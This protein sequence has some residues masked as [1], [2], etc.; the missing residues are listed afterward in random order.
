MPCQTHCFFGDL[1][2]HAADL[3]DNTS[4]FDYSYPVIHRTFTATHTGLGR[5]GRNRFIR[6]DTDPDFTTTLHEAGERDTSSLDLT[7]FHPACLQRLQSKLAKGEGA[8][9]LGLTFHATAMLAAIF[10]T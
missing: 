1:F 2:A 3:K 7:R 6:K 9:T 8:A 5:F 10:R 4:R